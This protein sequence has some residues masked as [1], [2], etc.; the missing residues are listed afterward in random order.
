MMHIVQSSLQL[1]WLEE[2]MLPSILPSPRPLAPWNEKI[3]YTQTHMSEKCLQK[4]R[5]EQGDNE[6]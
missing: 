2:Y 6:V 5:A 4:K 1:Q 3:T